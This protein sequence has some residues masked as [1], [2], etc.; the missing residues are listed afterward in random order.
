MR[1]HRGIRDAAGESS[2]FV[3]PEG[4]SGDR[5]GAVRAAPGGERDLAEAFGADLGRRLRRGLCRPER[6][7]SGHDVIHRHDDPEIHNTGDDQKVDDRVEE[8]T[9]FDV[10]TIDIE[11]DGALSFAA[12]CF[13][14]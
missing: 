12:F 10:P 6:F 7:G 4:E 11:D 14:L 3:E 8:V 1:R 13:S 9:N 2:I 5:L